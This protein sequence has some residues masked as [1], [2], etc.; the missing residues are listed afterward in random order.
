M[1][2]RS[3]VLLALLSSLALAQKDVKVDSITY[4]NDMQW[5]VYPSEGPIVAFAFKGNKLWYSTGQEVNLLYM[6]N[7]KMQ[8]VNKLGD[9]TASSVTSMATDCTGVIWIGTSDGVAKGDL[10]GFESFTAD[11]GLSD[12]A[13]TAICPA[14]GGKV[15]VGTPKGINLYQGN[16]WK[17]YTSKD[18]L[19]G[20][21]INCIA[22]DGKNRAWVGTDKGIGV[23]DG[24]SWDIH[25]MKRGMSWNNVKAIAID[26]RTDEVWAAV[27]ESDVNSYNGK[28]WKV[29]M[30]IKDDIVCMMVDTQGRVWFGSP[31]GLLKFN[32]DKWISDPK[33]LGI[34]ASSA[35]EMVC[36]RKGNMWF[37]T[38][39]GVIRLKN[40]YPF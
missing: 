34:T 14:R 39:R 11:N 6:Q 30:S 40:P 7:M 35:S 26:R 3:F 24:S 16:T 36:D 33:K 15:W 4:E 37:G 21:V 5:S 12:N 18:G 10:N 13:I 28:E 1:F 38:A 27:G 17:T 32:G 19:P 20:D 2:I 23:F 8:V 9:I 25:D 22:V 29:Y 31:T